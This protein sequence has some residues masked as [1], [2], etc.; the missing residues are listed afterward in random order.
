MECV[1]LQDEFHAAF[2]EVGHCNHKSLTNQGAIILLFLLLFLLPFA[3]LVGGFGTVI[4]EQ[5]EIANLRPPSWSRR[6]RS[7][8]WSYETLKANLS[9]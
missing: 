7:P 3:V 4:L 5:S 6:H 8:I 9:S 1:S 2:L